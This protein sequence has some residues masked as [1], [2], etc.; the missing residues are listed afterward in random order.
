VTGF[1]I[2]FFWV[3]RMTLMSTYFTEEMPFKDVYI[4]GLVR[5]E[6]GKKMSKS[7]NNHLS[8]CPTYPHHEDF[9]CKKGQIIIE[10]VQ[11]Y[12]DYVDERNE[13]N[14]STNYRSVK[15]HYDS[16]RSKHINEGSYKYKIPEEYRLLDKDTGVIVDIRTVYPKNKYK[17]SYSLNSLNTGKGIRTKRRSYKT[18]R[19]HKT[20]RR[21]KTNKRH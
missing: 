3:A 2:I 12:M 6:Q 7:A 9:P 18:N 10:N 21:H 8:Y 1:D 17:G 4:H 11:D 14:K 20:H 5:D 19:K 15:T 13:K 16:M